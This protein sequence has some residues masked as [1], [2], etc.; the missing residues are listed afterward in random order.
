MKDEERWKAVWAHVDSRRAELG[1]SWKRLYEEAGVSQ[2]TML[3]MRKH[4]TELQS[5]NKRVTLC[6]SLGWTPDSIERILAGGE[7]RL[8]ASLIERLATY[9]G[10]RGEALELTVG[11]FE[12]LNE[13]RHY[14]PVEPVVAR[15]ESYWVEH[16]AERPRGAITQREVDGVRQRVE[17]LERLVKSLF[18][19]LHESFDGDAEIEQ[20][21]D[22]LESER[23]TRQR[24]AQ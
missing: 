24:A 4:G 12:L 13:F 11:S 3:K 16:P 17:R 1:W 8:D 18:A 21:L 14:D 20:L 2:G 7:P 5:D 6:R 22:G 10:E 23:S 19:Q 15:L 9:Y